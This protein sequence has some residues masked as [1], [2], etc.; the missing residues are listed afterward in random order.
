VSARK[1]ID[2]TV[3]IN[4]TMYMLKCFLLK[5]FNTTLSV[6]SDSTKWV[7]QGHN[8]PSA[9]KTILL[10]VIFN[11][12]KSMHYCVRV[13]DILA[14]KFFTHTPVFFLKIR[15]A[16]L[17]SCNCAMDVRYNAPLPIPDP[18]LD[19]KWIL[20]CT[21]ILVAWALHQM[22]TRYKASFS[23]LAIY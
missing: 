8:V 20:P 10:F 4:V 1:D 11:N 19:I 14:I 16:P 12:I 7:W 17:K 23:W 21:V 3:V 5:W 15:L 13:S 18:S 22:K 6:E 9:W 2:H